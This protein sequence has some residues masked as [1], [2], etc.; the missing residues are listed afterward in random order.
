VAFLNDGN[1]DIDALYDIENLWAGGGDDFVTG[2]AA[3][4]ELRGGRGADTLRGLGGNDTLWGQG[5]N[6]RIEGG[7]GSDTAVYSDTTTSVRIDLV[8]QRVTFPG[9]SWLSETLVSIENAV[10]GSGR[11]RLI[12]TA[13]ANVLDGGLGADTIDGGVGRDT[14]SF[15]S[16]TQ[17]VRINLAL[18]TAGILATGVADTLVSLESATGG[19]GSDLLY[20][21]GRANALDGGL[22]NDRIWAGGGNDTVA[23]SL[24][25]D[26]VAGG[27]G[28]DTLAWTPTYDTYYDLTYFFY[29][30]LESGITDQEYDGDLDADLTVDLAAGAAVGGGFDSALA[31][32][33]NITTGVGNDHVIGSAAANRIS[34]GHGANVVDGG[35]GADTILGSNVESDDIPFYHYF[36]DVRD[37]SEVLRGGS[38]DDRIV[39]GTTVFGGGGDDTLVA[40]WARNAMTGGAGADDFVFSD[41]AEWGGWHSNSAYTQRGQI[42]DFD[43]GEGDRL[44]IDRVDD[45]A[46]L[47]AFAGYVASSEEVDVGEWG[48]VDGTD[49]FLCLGVAYGGN[50][51]WND[52]LGIT[53]EGNLTESDVIFV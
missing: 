53:V 19:A 43:G 35:G 34:V 48:I 12:G 17:G 2:N 33:E 16:H 41:E 44:V 45:T 40:G 21:D 22:G 37:R 13:G 9:T 39:G 20:G 3:A 5:G 18:Q 28:I 49:F 6:D 23:L 32:I 47:P 15:A 29:Y 31:S 11:D 46:P 1:A 24:G 42:I 30:Y 7:A 4:N 14:V 36:E 51:V 10:G 50:D 38:G 8:Q 27:A 52:G 25:H 26:Q